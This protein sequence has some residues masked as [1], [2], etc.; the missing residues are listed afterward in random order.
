MSDTKPWKRIDPTKVDKISYRTVVTKTFEMSNG[1]ITAFG[2]MWPEGQEFVCAIALT[3]DHHVIVA[4][5]FRVRPE[6]MMNELPGGY[7]DDGESV[8]TAGAR[9]L[10]EETGYVPSKIEYLGKTCKDAYANATWHFILATDCYIDPD[11]NHVPKIEEHIE[12][13]LI[14]IP[15]LIEDAKSGRM[16]DPVGVLIA[17]ERLKELVSI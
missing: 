11:I 9:E 13:R 15:E 2:T 3:K 1:E 4:R 10:R 17:L 6:Q 14:T 16:T 5:M 8:E 7:I 12:T